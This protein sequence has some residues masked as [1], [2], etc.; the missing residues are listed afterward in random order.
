MALFSIGY[1]EMQTANELLLILMENKIDVLVDVRS[2]PFSRKKAFNKNSLSVYLPDNG[3]DYAWKGDTLG[4]FSEIGESAIQKL[5][6]W[7]EGKRACLMCMEADPDHCHRKNE[8]AKRLEA[9]GVGVT[10]L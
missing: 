3:I 7:Q 6:K 1:Q 2:K 10:H 9:Y 8:I 4:G 5:A